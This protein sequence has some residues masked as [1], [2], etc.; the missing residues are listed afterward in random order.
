MFRQ[1]CTIEPLLF[2]KTSGRHRRP[3]EGRHLVRIVVILTRSYNCLF[4]QM[5]AVR[6]AFLEAPL[7]LYLASTLVMEDALPSSS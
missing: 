6:W 5:R 1:T 2:K 3:F 4:D 7:R